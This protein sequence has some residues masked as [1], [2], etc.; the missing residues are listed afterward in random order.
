MCQF[1]PFRGD[2]VGDAQ[3]SDSGR[4][5]AGGTG[6]GT[7]VSH[8]I[9]ACVESHHLVRHRPLRGGDRYDE[10]LRFHASQRG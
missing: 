2:A 3:L 5:G 1:P 8:P 7:G 10:L 4:R 9:S 6:S